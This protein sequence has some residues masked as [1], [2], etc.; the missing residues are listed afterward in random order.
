[1]KKS[2]YRNCHKCL[3]VKT[4][5]ITYFKGMQFLICQLYL[6]KAALSAQLLQK[7]GRRG[8]TSQRPKTSSK[9]KGKEKNRMR[10]KKNEREKEEGK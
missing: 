7:K 4:Y 5:L 3:H 9:N 6:N 10:S 8:Q 1:M 2:V